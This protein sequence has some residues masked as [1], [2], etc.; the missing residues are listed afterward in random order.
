MRR[1]Y[2]GT[3]SSLV[4][5]NHRVHQGLSR[6]NEQGFRDASDSQGGGE[7]ERGSLVVYQS[8]SQGHEGYGNVLHLSVDGTGKADLILIMESS[9]NIGQTEF[10]DFV[11]FRLRQL[12]CCSRE[13]EVR[14]SSH[15]EGVQRCSNLG[16]I[17]SIITELPGPGRLLTVKEISHKSNGLE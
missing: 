8:G 6:R 17:C 5:R 7:G 10:Q 4:S 15:F 16:T 2:R 13:E 9:A 11:S 14:M 1:E 3:V 12:Y